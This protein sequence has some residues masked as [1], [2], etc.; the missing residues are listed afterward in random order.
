MSKY[1]GMNFLMIWDW[2]VIFLIWGVNFDFEFSG[3]LP[4]LG[5]HCSLR[6]LLFTRTNVRTI[7]F[8]IFVG[9]FQNEHD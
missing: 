6:T 3:T 1:L 2:G 8:V 9:C 5:V 4:L 7:S